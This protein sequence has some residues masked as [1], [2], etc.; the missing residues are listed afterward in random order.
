MT[1]AER[2]GSPEAAVWARDEGLAGAV[3]ITGHGHQAPG[4]HLEALR[5][6]PFDTVLTPLNYVLG[7]DPAY[8]AAYRPWSPRSRPQDF[9]L[10]IIKAWRRNW[11]EPDGHGYST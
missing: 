5:R 6:L 4:T 10:M 11:L 8:L 7:Q 2:I 1:A 3:G 9:G